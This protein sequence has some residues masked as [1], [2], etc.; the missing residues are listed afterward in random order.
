M[1]LRFNQ[2]DVAAET[3]LTRGTFKRSKMPPMTLPTI[4][5]N[6]TINVTI[7]ATLG[8]GALLNPIW[9]T[10]K[11]P[12]C[13]KG[14]IRQGV[15][16]VKFICSYGYEKHGSSCI[17][18]ED[19]IKPIFTESSL[20]FF[21]CLIRQSP[22][23]Y[24]TV[25]NASKMNAINS[26]MGSEYQFKRTRDSD[27]LQI[28]T[29]VRNTSKLLKA[30]EKQFVNDNGTKF[31]Y[32]ISNNVHI[33]KL[34][35]FDVTRTFPN[36]SLCAN[37]RIFTVKP[38]KNLAKNCSIK[39]RKQ[40]YS[41][42]DYVSWMILR[43]YRSVYSMRTML[44]ICLS[45]YHTHNQQCPL[46]VLNN[47][48][49]ININGTASLH[50]SKVKL[51]SNQYLPW[52]NGIAF[53]FSKDYST[54][55]VPKWK[56]TIN[57][58]A[59]V[60]TM[61]GLPL[62]IICYI[63]VIAT[64]V[65]FKKLR[66]VPGYNNVGL[67]CSLLCSDVLFTVAIFADRTLCIGTAVLLHWTLLLSYAWCVIIGF[68]I[69]TKFRSSAAGLRI[70]NSFHRFYK[71][72]AFVFLVAT[73]TVTVSLILSAS[74]TIEFMYGGHNLCWIHNYYARVIGFLAPVAVLNSVTAGSLVYTIF[75]IHKEIQ[76]N[77][78]LQLIPTKTKI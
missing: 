26:F 68:E 42:S 41:S 37:R 17:K 53:C 12:S 39:R 43:N 35:G 49:S 10:S 25:R 50:Q 11:L 4:D 78:A 74:N 60:I 69:A 65:F 1:F 30:I 34:H 9:H 16:C 7:G 13:E 32:F 8:I 45:F 54:T 21:E 71:Y 48:F 73:A 63:W 55:Y 72:L 66:N 75:A 31:V 59:H 33:T 23:I 70:S 2:K 61:T 27:I 47:N 64:F 67:T 22:T 77:I 40:Y 20:P 38:G 57:K 18:K 36:N 28:I 24:M 44:S 29:D 62:S 3:N 19:R 58:I 15:D 5:D 14:F 52:H 56:I 46:Q 6:E 76:D 51:S